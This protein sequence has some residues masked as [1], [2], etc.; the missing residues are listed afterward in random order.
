MRARRLDST[1][2]EIVRTLKA[3]GATVL[4]ISA[5]NDAGAPDILVGY[6]RRNV[7]LEI[8]SPGRKPRPT[9]LEW[10]E[11][12]RGERPTTVWTT[13]DA[14]RAIGLEGGD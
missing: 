8:K 7:L 6:Q 12:W 10:H 5:E 14:L 9:Q 1:H 4:T 13:G 2:R 3:V 11:T